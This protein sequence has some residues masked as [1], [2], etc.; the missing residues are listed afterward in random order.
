MSKLRLFWNTSGLSSTMCAPHPS[1]MLP[2]IN[3]T[4]FPALAL[5]IC[6]NMNVCNLY[7]A[8]LLSVYVW[9]NPVSS[10]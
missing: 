1:S 8:G 10:S 7:E 9:L 3:I 4:L 2:Y 5:N 6:L